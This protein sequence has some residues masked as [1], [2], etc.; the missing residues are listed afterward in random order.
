MIIRDTGAG[1]GSDPEGL[2]NAFYTTK[3]EGMGIGLSV[4]RSIIESHK[5]RIWAEANDGQGTTFV[6][7]L[8]EH[9]SL[10]AEL[11]RQMQL[12]AGRHSPG[13]APD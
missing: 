2:F 9:Q 8:P 5:G 7:E 1:F 10:E 6:F 13:T 11:Q 4:S 12:G 3:H